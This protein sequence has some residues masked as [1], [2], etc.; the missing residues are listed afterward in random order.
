M[1]KQISQIVTADGQPV[2]AATS[3][4]G[5][6]IYN[7]QKF[8]QHPDIAWGDTFSDPREGNDVDFYVTGAEYFT[9]LVGAIAA[10]KESIYIT[11]WQVNFDVELTPGVTLFQCL[12]KAIDNNDRLKIF[13]MPWL[14]PKVGVDTGDFETMLAIFQ[15]NAGLKDKKMRAFALP[16]IA[17]SDMP[18][19]LGIG[20]SHHQKLVV[21]DD[22]RAFVGGIDVAYGRRDDGRFL[23][24]HDG[25]V[26]NELY[27]TCIPPVENISAV[28]Q[29]KYLTRAELFAACFDGKAG[30]TGT[31]LT[32]APMLPI[33]FVQDVMAFVG[34]SAA[35]GKK[36]IG[37]RWNTADLTPGFVRAA[38]DVPVD[39]AQAASRFAYAEMNRRLNGK[40][41]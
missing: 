13:V 11:G 40:L 32:S 15:L 5:C 8:P 12:E 34:N 25:R 3:A 6:F 24:S 16:A 35:D 14:S 20:F 27:N 17:Q 21:I 38:Q 29:T 2:A 23:L 22:R 1:T 9:A 31:F 37:D 30:K 33:A 36:W 28:D 26:G 10:A 39:F 18:A 7:G 4:P 41:A 19:G